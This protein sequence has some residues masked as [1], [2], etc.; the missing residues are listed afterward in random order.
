MLR[1]SLYSLE[2]WLRG[3]D[4]NPRFQGY[5][6]CEIPD[7]STPRSSENKKG[8]AASYSPTA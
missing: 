5:E 8:L 4:L 2:N 7:F 1:K 3:W 6:P